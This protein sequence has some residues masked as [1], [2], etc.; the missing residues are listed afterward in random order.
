[1]NG[2]LLDCGCRDAEKKAYPSAYSQ[3]KGKAPLFNGPHSASWSRNPRGLATVFKG[4]PRPSMSGEISSSRYTCVLV[5]C[6]QW[7][8]NLGFHSSN[9]IHLTKAGWPAAPGI[10]LSP[11][12]S[13]G[14]R[15]AC[16]C[17]RPASTPRWG[18]GDYN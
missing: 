12:S 14:I 18:S 6:S 17:A 7:S 4:T 1:M 2:C 15:N 8:V 5:F 16:C 13:T 3:S 11:S 10:G 9:T